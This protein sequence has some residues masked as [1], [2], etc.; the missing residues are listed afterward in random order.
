MAHS[1]RGAGGG[2]E[3]G[4]ELAPPLPPPPTF[5]SSLPQAPGRP[6]QLPRVLRVTAAASS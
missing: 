1:Q 5:S 3:G 4:V 6:D 2:G